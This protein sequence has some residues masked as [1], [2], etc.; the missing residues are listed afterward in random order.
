LID[1]NSN[2][3]KKG[4][5]FNSVLPPN[6]LEDPTKMKEDSNIVSLKSS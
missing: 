5:G 6:K 4:S 2:S 3:V 1:G